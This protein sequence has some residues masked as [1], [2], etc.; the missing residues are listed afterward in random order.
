MELVQEIL[1]ER[2]QPG[3][4]DRNEYGSRMGGGG[5]AMDVSERGGCV[6]R[7]THI[8]HHRFYLY[9]SEH[10]P[11]A[12]SLIYLALSNLLSDWLGSSA[13]TLCR[14]GDWSQRGDDQ[15]D[16]ERRRS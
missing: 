3:F 11:I 6:W 14:G 2:D 1:R 4:G 12:I 10:L 13:T 15:E 7:G 8:P 9:E 16:S 5:G